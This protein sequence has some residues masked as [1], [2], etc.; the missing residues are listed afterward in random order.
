MHRITTSQAF[1]QH[2]SNYVFL[3]KTHS[4]VFLEKH[5]HFFVTSNICLA[6]CAHS[7]KF[8]VTLID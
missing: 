1:D 2:R 6:V 8:P 7:Q 5:G 4:A 3:G